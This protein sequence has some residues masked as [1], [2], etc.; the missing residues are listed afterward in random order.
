MSA[1]QLKQGLTINR[2]NLIGKTPR[3]EIFDFDINSIIVRALK[4]LSFHV[5]VF[6]STVSKLTI[7]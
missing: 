1:I 5:L 2:M 6:G 3:T 4:Y 7:Y